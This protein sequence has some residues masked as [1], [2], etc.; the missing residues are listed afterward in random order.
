MVVF[1]R[2]FILMNIKINNWVNFWT[3]RNQKA[4]MIFVCD[5]FS[6]LKN[7]HQREYVAYKD[8]IANRLGISRRFFRRISCLRKIRPTYKEFWITVIASCMTGFCKVSFS[9]QKRTGFCFSSSCCS[10]C[11]VNVTFV[12]LHISTRSIRVLILGYWY[13]QI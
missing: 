1:L 7:I 5:C 2:Y 13:E 6:F 9:W 3:K 8:L 11:S 10:F 4:H 12:E